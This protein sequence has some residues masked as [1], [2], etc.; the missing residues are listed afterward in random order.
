[1]NCFN[2]RPR[3]ADDFPF[4]IGAGM[5][6]IPLGQEVL[7]VLVPDEVDEFY[8]SPLQVCNIGFKQD[9]II[10]TCR[11][12]IVAMHLRERQIEA[13]GLDTS[14]EN[15]HVAEEFVPSYLEPADIVGMVNDAHGI[16]IRIDSSDFNGLYLQ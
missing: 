5:Y 10:K 1:M 3:D 8:T 11:H 12:M 14:G 4:S 13:R 16:G 15:G 9:E 7:A 2:D 6:G